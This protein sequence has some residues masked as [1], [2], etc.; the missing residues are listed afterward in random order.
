MLVGLVGCSDPIF[1]YLEDN[2]TNFS[3]SAP[4][5][6]IMAEDLETG[7]V[8]L[9]GG[10]YSRPYYEVQYNLLTHLHQQEGFQYLLTKMGY[11]SAAVLNR[12]LE[13]GEQELLDQVLNGPARSG[14]R[15]WE[16]QFW[17][18]LY[19]YNHSFPADQRIIILGIGAENN[20]S[21]AAKF[22]AGLQNVSQLPLL[23]EIEQLSNL[24]DAIQEDIRN[25]YK[26]YRDTLGD[27]FLPFEITIN[28]IA[29]GAN[30]ETQSHGKLMYEN[31]TKLYEHNPEAKFFGQ[32]GI[33]DVFQKDCKPFA[34]A[35]TLAMNLNSPESPVQGR[36]VSVV[37]VYH[38]PESDISEDRVWSSLQKLA[39]DECTLYRLNGKGSPFTKESYLV[40]EPIDG[41]TTDH[42]QYILAIDKGSGLDQAALEKYLANNYISLD[43]DKPDFSLMARDLATVSVILG[44]ESHAIQK[45]YD[46]RFGLLTGLH[47]QY[48]FNYF[49]CEIGYGFSGLLNQ[50]LATGNKDILIR[51]SN[52]SKGTAVWCFEFEEFWERLYEYNRQLPED[53]RILVFGVDVEHQRETAIDYI[54]TLNGV[55]QLPLDFNRLKSG[56]YLEKILQDLEDNPETYANALEEDLFHFEIVIRNLIATRQFYATEDNAL[57]ERTMYE[58]FLKIYAHYPEGKFFGQFGMEHVFQENCQTFLD[59]IDRFAML[60][61]SCDSPVQGKVLSIPYYYLNCQMSNWSNHYAHEDAYNTLE[62]YKIHALAQADYTLFRLNGDA[63]PFREQPYMVPNPYHGVTTDYFQ[64]VLVIKDSPG[65]TTPYTSK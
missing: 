24:V 59:G 4:N 16:R 12:Y 42:F 25:N 1:D 58:N 13:T 47:Q 19:D 61:M 29:A 22:I 62:A 52:Q 6:S 43:L 9:W 37:H 60:L 56:Y 41:V 20:P 2:H 11:G 50:Y 39:E 8:I 46:V 48:G 45:N 23:A 27:D 30:P 32:F 54:R 3:V 31:F 57:R 34:G 7:Q 36:V 18:C 53:Q 14:A 15:V 17:Q 28:S 55:E 49:L 26:L 44:G 40:P 5:L 63:S 64:Y 10:D 35:N 21:L 51:L 33:I 38:N 65:T